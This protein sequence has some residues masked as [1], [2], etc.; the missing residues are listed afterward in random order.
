MEYTA[1]AVLLLASRAVIDACRREQKVPHRAPEMLKHFS[2]SNAAHD[3]ITRLYITYAY[4]YYYIYASSS[5]SSFS[6]YIIK[7]NFVYDCPS[8]SILI[9]AKYSAVCAIS[10][11]EQ[12]L[13]HFYVANFRL[14][15]TAVQR[16]TS[17]ES[18]L[19]IKRHFSVYF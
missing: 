12:V 11:Y 8:F 6:I 9:F 2:T 17:I 14:K 13:H 16:S 15:T 19:I 5:Y 7:A 4:M 10:E 3:H 18:I 1:E